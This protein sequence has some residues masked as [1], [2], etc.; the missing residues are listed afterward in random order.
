VADTANGA[1]ITTAL[2]GGAAARA[3]LAAGD[4][5]TSLDGKAVTGGQSLS[6]VLATKRPG[7]TV[8]VQYLD[9]DGAR[10][11]TSVQLASGPPQ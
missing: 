9:G 1:Q 4:T 5:I 11:T 10:H 6:D 8:Q 2:S 7:D 3:G